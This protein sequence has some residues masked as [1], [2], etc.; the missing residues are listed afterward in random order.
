MQTTQDPKSRMRIPYTWNQINKASQGCRSQ[1]KTTRSGHRR[2]NIRRFETKRG[3]IEHAPLGLSR[4]ATG[5]GEE[6]KS[7]DPRLKG[8]VHR[9][10]LRGWGSQLQHTDVQRFDA[11]LVITRKE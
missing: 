7:L 9:P 8:C 6:R 2:I 10:P 11:T 1:L 4:F 3:V 5:Q